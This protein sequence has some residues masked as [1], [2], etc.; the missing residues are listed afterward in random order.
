MTKL[1]KNDQRCKHKGKCA[2]GPEQVHELIKP[3]AT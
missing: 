3:D 1:M 2:D